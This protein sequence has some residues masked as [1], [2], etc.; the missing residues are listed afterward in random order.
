VARL[1]DKIGAVY[2]PGWILLGDAQE[3]TGA[4]PLI[5]A[6]EDGNR[7][8]RRAL[9]GNAFELAEDDVGSPAYPELAPDEAAARRVRDTRI[10]EAA[11]Q[12]EADLLVTARRYLRDLDWDFV[13]RIVVAAPHSALPLVGLYLRRQGVYDTYGSSDGGARTTL[14]RGLFFWVATRDLLPAAWRWLSACVRAGEEGGR[15][16]YLAQS[17]L[18]RVDRALQERDEVL[19]A[20]NQPQNND[21]ASDALDSLDGVLLRLMGAFDVTARVAHRVLALGDG[22]Y[23]AGWQSRSWRKRVAT[24]APDLAALVA[25]GSPGAHIVEVV[26]LLRNSIHGEALRPLALGTGPGRLDETMVGLPPAD[27]EALVSAMDALG[28]RESFGV[29]VLFPGRIHADPGELVDEVFRRAVSVLDQLMAMTPV[30]LIVAEPLAERDHAPPEDDIFGVAT[31][32]SIRLQ[33]GLG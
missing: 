28:G 33:L 21:I 17:A 4:I 2:V 3:G 20:L 24:S 22:E 32:E 26:R 15:L 18:Q 9:V 5:Q 16:A 27:A 29:R 12:V 7:I 19:W 10:L 11:I 23:R 13:H 1:S 25:P 6:T 30:E 14:N 8:A 31:R